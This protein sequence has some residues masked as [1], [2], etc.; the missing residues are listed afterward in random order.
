MLDLP[1]WL[2]ITLGILLGPPLAG[3]LLFMAGALSGAEKLSYPRAPLGAVAFYA[4]RVDGAMVDG[5]AVR[6]QPGG[7]YG[8]WITAEVAGP[9]KGDP[10][11]LSW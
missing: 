4:D 2:S 3:L 5:E 8:G 1:D 10:G 7:F 9:F 6:P 11:T